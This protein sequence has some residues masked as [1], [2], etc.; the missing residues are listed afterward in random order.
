[1]SEEVPVK[2][3]RRR[4]TKQESEL[5]KKE[6]IEIMKLYDYRCDVSFKV[7]KEKFVCAYAAP[8][9]NEAKTHKERHWNSLEGEWNR[10]REYE[11]KSTET[12]ET[13]K[14]I[15]LEVEHVV[16]DL[17]GGCLGDN[18]VESYEFLEN[19]PETSNE[20]NNVFNDNFSTPKKSLNAMFPTQTP[21]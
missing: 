17:I 4:I 19:Y 16:D 20:F 3:K 7:G 18:S 21:P 11:V 14:T 6:R 8:Y 5:R 1:M 12:D 15:H 13:R 2:K 9:E 10:S